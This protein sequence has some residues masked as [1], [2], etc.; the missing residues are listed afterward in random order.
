[1][2]RMTIRTWSI[3]NLKI[4][5]VIHML[6]SRS[7]TLNRTASTTHTK[8]QSDGHLTGLINKGSSLSSPTA[9]GL[10][11]TWIRGFARCL[12]EEFSSVYVLHLRGNARTSGERRRSEGGNVFGGGSRAPVSIMILVKNP[13][14]THDGCKI[15]YRDIGDYL[16]REQK[17]EAL[18][19]AVSIKGISDWQTITPNT[20]YD[21]I[22]QRSEAFD[23][24]Y[25]LGSQDAK[26]GKADD[27]IFRL[28]S[29]GLSNWQR[30]IHL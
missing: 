23:Q 3:L 12:A 28:Y 14:A 24:F 6:R 5:L 9:H 29:R 20:D 10:T 8:W 30:C 26:A 4:A 16:T 7:T 21:W 27:A 19:E 13:N 11:E 22:D 15:H 2:R 18:T 25:P 17:L 1:M